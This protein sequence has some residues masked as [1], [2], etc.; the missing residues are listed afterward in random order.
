MQY[1]GI[2]TCGSTAGMYS[3]RSCGKIAQTLRQTQLPLPDDTRQRDLTCRRTRR[4]IRCEDDARSSRRP[5]IQRDLRT[6]GVAW[7]GDLPTSSL[8]RRLGQDDEVNGRRRRLGVIP[9]AVPCHPRHEE[10]VARGAEEPSAA[11]A[12]ERG[13]GRQHDGGIAEQHTRDARAGRGHGTSSDR[14]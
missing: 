11:I 3:R 8:L 7:W 4:R 12:M 5:H 13:A 1:S 2:K 6:C 14:G 10:V 9:Q